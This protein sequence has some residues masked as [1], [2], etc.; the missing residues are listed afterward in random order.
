MRVRSC[1]IGLFCFC[2]IHASAQQSLIDSLESIVALNKKDLGTGWALNTLSMELVRND[3][4]KAKKYLWR[5]IE[6]GKSLNHGRTLSAAYSLL[7]TVYQNAAQTDS[8]LFYLNSL[9][10]LSE[11]NTVEDM[12]IIRPNYFS[13]A[14]LYY[15]KEG[16]YKEA[17]K[18]FK[19]AMAGAE[20]TGNKV[21]ASGQAINI[22]N[23][24]LNLSDYN[25]ALKFY[26]QALK[27]FEATGNKKG[28]SFCYQNICECYTELK[29]YNAALT[30]VNKSIKLKKELNDKRGLGNAEQALG[31][32]TMACGILINLFFITQML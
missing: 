15:K 7:V 32:F 30:Y 27:G 17:L 10:E 14:G 3:V 4:N 2:I 22:G 1:I 25:S 21:S 31:R 13:A 19:K 16:N 23:I 28:Q 26:L 6:I 29:Q 9:K 24:Y 11:K 8:A 5:A 12:D 18:Y 20:K